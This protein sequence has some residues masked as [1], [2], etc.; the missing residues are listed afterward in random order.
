M[1]INERLEQGRI[2]ARGID[3]SVDLERAYEL[4]NGIEN[5]LAPDDREVYEW[6]KDIVAPADD[7]VY[8]QNGYFGSYS[9]YMMTVADTVDISAKVN[10]NEADV[11]KKFEELLS[12]AKREGTVD[13][14]Y[15]ALVR[16]SKSRSKSKEEH[17]EY[18]RIG[19]NIG[20]II[21]YYWRSIDN[22]FV[23]MNSVRAS[24]GLPKRKSIQGLYQVVGGKNGMDNDGKMILVEMTNKMAA[25]RQGLKRPIEIRDLNL[26]IREFLDLFSP[27]KLDDKTKKLLELN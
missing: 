24:K 26:P 18:T 3:Q 5:F 21:F 15:N 13:S 25:E 9:Q 12:I 1:T 23:Q 7:D 10:H 8:F 27:V 2:C 4:W 11:R 17:P 20:Y 19:N 14:L 16:Y 6:I 22:F